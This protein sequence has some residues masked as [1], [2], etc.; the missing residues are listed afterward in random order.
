M[1][2]KILPHQSYYMFMVITKPNHAYIR[3]ITLIGEAD[4]YRALRFWICYREIRNAITYWLSL[5]SVRD[6]SRELWSCLIRS[7][8][9]M[10]GEERWT[11]ST[12]AIGADACVV[13]VGCFGLRV[14]RWLV[15]AHR[16]LFKHSHG[17]SSA[18]GFSDKAWGSR[19]MYTV[20]H[21]QLAGRGGWSLF[22][23]RR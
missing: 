21:L 20:T 3:Q 9:C 7:E 11:T 5:F 16:L 17:C 18:T 10:I 12:I 2:N 13:Q 23:S 22:V 15:V 4:I 8:H 1:K 6:H 14:C 19:T